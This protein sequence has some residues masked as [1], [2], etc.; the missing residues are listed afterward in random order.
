MGTEGADKGQGENKLS[1]HGTVASARSILRRG[2]MRAAFA[3]LIACVLALAVGASS[4]SAAEPIVKLTAVSEVSYASASFEGSV[5]NTGSWRTEVST[6][7]VHWTVTGGGYANFE[8]KV[9]QS[10]AGGL[11]GSTKYFVRLTGEGEAGQLVS[12]PS[13]YLSFT[14]LSVDPPNVLS[15]AH[16]TA[17]NH[18]VAVSGSVERPANPNPAF[19]ANCSF[20]YITDANFQA[21]NEK[22]RLT[23]AAGG[24]NYTLSFFNPAGSVAQTTAPVAFNGNAASV[25]AALQ[26]LPNIGAGNVTVTGGPGNK[27]GAFPYTITFAGTLGSKNLEQ[28]SVD[29]TNL[30]E[31][32]PTPAAVTTVTEGHAEGFEGALE[33]PCKP[34]PLTTPG[35]D[36]VATKLTGLA[37]DTTYHLRLSA[38]NAGGTDRK[39]GTNFTTTSKINAQTLSPGSIGSTEVKL[40]G[41]VNAENAPL[42]YQFEWG[43]TAAYGNVVPAAPEALP[44]VDEEVHFVT[45]KLSGLAPSTVYHYRIIATN[46]QTN[47]VLEGEGVSFETRA[48]NPAT[49]TCPN[50]TSRV[51]NSAGLPDCRAIEF[52]SPGLNNAGLA[53]P[54]YNLPR[55]AA[56]ADG[57]GVIFIMKDAPLNSESAGPYNM[58]AAERL[59][60]GGWTTRSTNPPLASAE[61]NFFGIIPLV[62]SED[63]REWTIFSSVPP[64]G[65]SAPGLNGQNGYI[66]LRRADGTWE[67]MLEKPSYSGYGEILNSKNFKHFFFEDYEPQYEGDPG[68]AFE[69]S[70]EEHVLRHIGVL[71]GGGLAPDA[72]VPA[73]L[74]LEPVSANG[75]IVLFGHAGQSY[76]RLHHATT[77]EVSASQR[78]PADPVGPQSPINVGITSDGSQVL[79]FSKSELTEDAYTGVE[80]AGADLYSYD[81]ATEKLTDLTVDTNPADVETGA[82]VTRVL[83]VDPSAN[84]VYF[85][86]TGK[87]AAGAVSG[88]EN[89]YVV[90]NGQIKFVAP[91]AG[92]NPPGL[93]AGEAAYVTPD[94]SHLAF[95]STASLT[96][97][98]NENPTTNEPQAMA[99]EYTYG[100]GIECASCR[101][102]GTP[103]TKPAIFPIGADYMTKGQRNRVLSDDGSRMFFQSGDQIIPQA[104]N[105]QMNV[106][107]YTQGAPHLLSPGDTEAPVYLLDASASGDDVYVTTNEEL[108]S[109][110]Q[111]TNTAIYDVRVNA[112]VVPPSP[113][114]PCTGENCRGPKT[115]APAQ[116]TPATAGFDAPGSLVAPKSLK[117]A[118]PSISLRVYVPAGGQ[119]RVNGKGLR[120]AVKNATAAGFVTVALK[121]K[122]SAAKQRTARGLFKSSAQVLFTPNSGEAARASVALRFETAKKKGGK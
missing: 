59:P 88:E 44:T 101:P 66:F 64:P 67:R 58:T 73:G 100:Q 50:A 104:A 12:S 36:A 27:T 87:L 23:I 37:A 8:P 39:A 2:R 24:G 76:A 45:E 3:T 94:G 26:A 116:T 65:V 14:T 18:T 97:Y 69:Y 80:D 61:T 83:A 43:T 25:Q 86:A 29:P 57:S 106:F 6:D 5:E 79:F 4:A 93:F 9:V 38:T 33:A 113:P 22:Q 31:P 115:T 42:T 75:E 98:D 46:T 96:G 81:T 90:H 21:R 34:N 92:I 114:T 10:G 102:D 28:L 60:G 68:G 122:Q 109:G 105:K 15:I 30:T 95:L 117:A 62:V 77:E 82:N 112:Q 103:P 17:D 52:A 11:Q 107:E 40:A 91:A 63:R 53:G 54:P 84:Y 32:G 108:T 19:D 89:L 20:E 49:E 55:G 70:A 51:G 74:L 111:G 1:H 78:H 71:P 99:F 120:P 72:A 48:A 85:I 119:V 7:E 13:P 56:S 41:R 35:A 110:S 118:K 47:E 16:G 121:L